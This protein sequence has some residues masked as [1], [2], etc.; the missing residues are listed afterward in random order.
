MRY[1]RYK[2]HK[3]SNHIFHLPIQPAGMFEGGGEIDP[4]MMYQNKY[5]TPLTP[6]EQKQFELWAK[7]NKINPM[8]KG[9]YDIQGYWKSGEWKNNTDPNNHGPDTYKKPNHPTFSR[10]SIYN[11]ADGF[12]GGN[13]TKDGGYQPSKQTLQLYGEKRYDWEFSREPNRPEH[14]DMSRYKSGANRGIPFV[15][16]KGGGVEDKP[17]P[18]IVNDPNDP[19]LRAYQ[20]S[21]SLFNMNNKQWI[22][23]GSVETSKEDYENKKK[24]EYSLPS[25]FF[26]EDQYKKDKKVNK[27]KNF[28]DYVF[29]LWRD[30]SKNT[31]KVQDAF[32]RN[33]GKDFQTLE[34]PFVEKQKN[35][36]EKLYYQ[37]YKGKI[38]KSYYTLYDPVT[39]TSKE[40]THDDE[41]GDSLLNIYNENIKPVDKKYY[42][43]KNKENVGGITISHEETKTEN[44]AKVFE[45]K[46]KNKYPEYTYG[47]SMKDVYMKP[48]WQVLYDK[49]KYNPNDKRLNL[50]QESFNS[51]FNSKKPVVYQA[52]ELDK[53]G[54]TNDGEM[55]L[56]T[57]WMDYKTAKTAGIDAKPGYKYY[58]KNVDG[59]ITIVEQKIQPNITKTPT[60]EANL[61]TNSQVK[62]D[63]TQRQVPPLPIDNTVHYTSA[64]YPMIGNQVVP[65]GY[66]NKPGNQADKQNAE[67]KYQH[68]GE[69]KYSIID[70]GTDLTPLTTLQTKLPPINMN[71]PKG[72]TYKGNYPGEE[73]VKIG[74]NSMG[75]PILKQTKQKL[76]TGEAEY[77]PLETAFMP[78]ARGLGWLGNMA[79]DAITG[80][81]DIK[82]AYN[83]AKTMYK[84]A[85]PIL[86]Q[87]F[88]KTRDIMN[89]DLVDLVRKDR[90]FL[91]PPPPDRN[92]VIEIENNLETLDYRPGSDYILDA[93]IANRPA[94]LNPNNELI[95]LSVDNITKEHF[96]PHL[97][98]SK[99]VGQTIGDGV[100]IYHNNGVK[101]VSMEYP[102]KGISASFSYYPDKNVMT[103]L[104][105]FAPLAN[106]IDRGRFMQSVLN[107]LPKNLIIK[108]TS[109]SPD[110]Y[111][112]KLKMAMNTKKY[113]ALSPNSEEATH[114]LPNTTA[115]S[116]APSILRKLMEEDPHEAKKFIDSH[117]DKINE[118]YQLNIPHSTIKRMV[119]SRNPIVYKEK[120]NFPNIDIMK[121]YKKGGK[122]KPN[123][124]KIID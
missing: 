40:F 67:I 95:D 72:Q 11:G 15:Y 56:D 98:S 12:Y 34:K 36:T 101:Y 79:A 10:E 78:A 94:N 46:S 124:Y 60:L 35:G 43:L 22:Y 47:T 81:A 107:A 54:N 122:I 70:E 64:G 52:K 112:N 86:K 117:I 113:K 102:Q 123:T 90:S 85:K 58:S 100:K 23:P 18:I 105:L 71:M 99:T 25:Y 33:I 88:E 3:T 89:A 42:A 19:R 29:A 120:P 84:N 14:L 53:A 48:V 91:P 39:K 8:D 30:E 109:L 9:A 28:N 77:V 93:P 24:Y 108:E 75:K 121:L 32:Q 69:V 21:L 37:K 103:D 63:L 74:T 49:N 16:G 6:S 115:T 82:S 110:S 80:S 17:K 55:R 68:G 96:T 66:R 104:G 97:I 45:E 51:T 87:G 62:P 26:D 13:W 38:D 7:A 4:E 118:L 44:G 61:S 41:Y 119:V 106:P 116:E 111:Y 114:T 76:A 65:E 73:Y 31:K 27:V 57:N 20:D 50:L 92:P 2:K 59:K 1:R 83:A 5:N